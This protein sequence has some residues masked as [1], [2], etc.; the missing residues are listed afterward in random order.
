MGDKLSAVT[1]CISMTVCTSLNDCVTF[2]MT[3]LNLTMRMAED[4]TAATFSLATTDELLGVLEM[5][6]GQLG[7]NVHALFFRFD[8]QLILPYMTPA[9]LDMEDGDVVDVYLSRPSETGKRGRSESPE[10]EGRGK[11]MEQ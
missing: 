5:Y 10:D 1:G 9:Q 7:L 3:T 11:R 2:T 8:G 4:N 6:S